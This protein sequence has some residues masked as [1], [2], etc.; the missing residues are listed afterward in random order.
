MVEKRNLLI[1]GIAMSEALSHSQLE[2]L[3]LSVL[4]CDDADSLF[5]GSGL[6]LIIAEK[7]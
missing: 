3:V 2:V 1:D 7:I 4:F 6:L 5:K